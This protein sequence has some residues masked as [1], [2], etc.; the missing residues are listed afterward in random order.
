MPSQANY[1]MAE[2]SGGT[3]STELAQKLLADFNILI[4]DLHIKT[5]GSYIRLAV[6]TPD[7]NNKLLQALHKITGGSK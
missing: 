7:D 4:K 1:I 3:D 5:G 6:K 2:I